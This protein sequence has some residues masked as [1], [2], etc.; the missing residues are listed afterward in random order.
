MPSFTELLDNVL[1]ETIKCQ[2]PNSPESLGRGSGHY[3]PLGPFLT[4]PSIGSYPTTDAAMSA[5]A[6]LADLLAQNDAE[7]SRTHSRDAVRKEIAHVVA[8]SLQIITKEG[9]AKKRWRIVREDLKRRLK[10]QPVELMHYFPVWLF[11]GQVCPSFSIGP[12]KF[13]QRE[14]WLNE[15][16]ARR[17]KPSSWMQGVRDRWAGTRTDAGDENPPSRDDLN[18][19]R[20]ARAV[21]P[22]QWVACVL[23]EGFEKDES[24]RRGLLAARVAIDTIRMLLPARAGRG[25]GTAL[26]YSAPLNVDKLLQG[27]GEDL[28]MGSTSTF[29]GLSGAPG[30]AQSIV[31]QGSPLFD[32]AGRCLEVAT[33]A[34]PLHQ[35]PGLAERWFNAAHWFGLASVAEADFTAT[36]MYV[37]GLDVLCGG[38]E[39]VGITELV[40][41]LTGT[42]LSVHV[43]PGKTLAVLVTEHYKLRSEIAHGSILAALEELDEQRAVLSQLAGAALV[44][45]ALKLDSY[46]KSG[47]R[48]DR[49]AFRNSLPAAAP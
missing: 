26:D 13:V 37:I 35:C 19:R 9:D 41:R 7:L 20:V 21:H 43:L 1:D 42:P 30:L 4:D 17:G 45:Y 8:S 16:E 11:V 18:V 36:V 22:D 47:G 6:E 5:L 28:A 23:V 10:N 27:R 31:T 15:I 25:L 44:E 48:D 3:G 33:A 40:A 46:A 32:A 34:K 38:L 2:D 14:E 29:P 12:V 49:D 39:Q 24:R